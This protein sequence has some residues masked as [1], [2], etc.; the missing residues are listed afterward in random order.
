V[1]TAELVHLS[2]D[3]LRALYFLHEVIVYQ[4]PHQTFLAFLKLCHDLLN[5]SFYIFIVAGSANHLLLRRTLRRCE[6]LR[7]RPWRWPEP[8]E[9]MKYLVRR[10]RI[11]L[12]SGLL[13]AASLAGRAQSGDVVESRRHHLL[14]ASWRWKVIRN[15][16]AFLLEPAEQIHAGRVSRNA[17]RVAL[18]GR[19]DL[20]R[21]AC[22]TGDSDFFEPS[23]SAHRPDSEC[24][25]PPSTATFGGYETLA[26]LARLRRA[27][28]GIAEPP[29][30]P[31]SID[32]KSS[33]P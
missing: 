32:A 5:N 21:T 15:R 29:R 7:R 20:F 3:H 1:H 16:W 25:F 22:A 12:T 10:I 2:D 30:E 27:R 11:F 24:P 6:A 31:S 13:Q 9:S 26:R 17:D 28:A 4:N 19:S 23:S 33:W 14:V 18:P 8:R